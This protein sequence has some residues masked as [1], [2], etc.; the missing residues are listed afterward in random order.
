MKQLIER[1]IQRKL[2]LIDTVYFSKEAPSIGELAKYLDVSEST[3]KSDLTQFN[4]L[5]DNGSIIRVFDRDRRMDLYESIVNDSLIS[6]VLRMLFMNPGRQA[7][8]YSDTLSISRANFY[9]QV[10][11]LNNRLKVYGARIIVNDGYHII[12]DDERAFRFFVFFSFVSTS[13]ENSPIIVENVHYFQDILKKN[14]L[15]VSHFNRVDSWERSYMASILAI[16]IIRQSNKKTEIEITQEQIMKSPINVSTPDVNRIRTV[17]TSA[18]Y[19]SI[20]EALI[21]YKEVLTDAPQSISSE[22]IVEL[23]ERYELEIQQ[24]FQVEKRQ[25]MIDTLIDIFSVVK[26]LSKYY[27]FDT[28]GSSITMRDFMNEYRII[29]VDVINRFNTFLQI[30]TEVM[31]LD[32][33][34]YQEMLFYWIVISIGDYLFVPRKRILFISRYNEKHLDFC[35]QDLETVL[36]IMKIEPVIDLMPIK[37]FN[38]DTKI[39]RYDLILSDATL[40]I[41]DDS[42]IIYKPF[43]NSILIVEGIMK[44]I[45]TKDD[46]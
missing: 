3:I 18:T 41:E 2:Q 7:E 1:H 9:K 5:A 6:K 16:F 31:G 46:Q 17:L 21:E 25:L 26:N 28:K 8:Y 13:T 19:K 35:Q 4:L 27:P 12:A 14:N 44:S 36:R 40:N 42:N 10:N 22:Q 32:L 39:D 24:T 37:R 20:L 34:L 43:S 29:N 33:M 30:A 45:N 38:T 15:G 11:L 23:L